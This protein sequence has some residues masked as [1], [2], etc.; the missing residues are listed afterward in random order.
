MFLVYDFDYSVSPAHAEQVILLALR[1][2]Q[3]PLIVFPHVHCHVTHALVLPQ[4]PEA[5]VAVVSARH[6][7]EALRAKEDGGD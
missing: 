3:R 5:Q 1:Q 6:Q 4:V 7:L 2:A